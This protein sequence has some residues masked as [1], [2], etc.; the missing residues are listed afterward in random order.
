MEKEKYHKEKEAKKKIGSTTLI[1]IVV[2]AVFFI[3]LIGR[4]VL[5]DRKKDVSTGMPTSEDTYKVAKYFITPTLKSSADFSDSKFQYAK[6]AD[7]VYIIKSFYESKNDAGEKVKTNFVIT[8][9][10]K[11]GFIDNQR[12]WELL[13]LTQD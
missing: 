2:F 8:L 6:N 5:S 11:G 10:Y 7:S 13:N 1:L 9:K 3:L 4:F 12:S